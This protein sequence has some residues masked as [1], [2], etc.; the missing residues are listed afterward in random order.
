MHAKALPHINHKLSL[1]NVLAQLDAY[2]GS[3]IRD[4]SGA[5]GTRFTAQYARPGCDALEC[6]GSDCAP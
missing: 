2:D 3:R 1:P 6:D 4:P 5:R